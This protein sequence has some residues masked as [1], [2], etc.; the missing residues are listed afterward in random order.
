MPHILR[1]SFLLSLSCLEKSSE[2][3]N[4]EDTE[5]TEDTEEALTPEGEQLGDC[6]DGEDNDNDGAIDC[7]DSGCINATECQES[8]TGAPD[9][10]DVPDDTDD[11]TD[12]EP[13][14]SGDDSD[15]DTEAPQEFSGS[16]VVEVDYINPT[17][18]SIGYEDCTTA[19]VY[20]EIT[21][22][23][24]VAGCP[25]CTHQWKVDID[26]STDCANENPP[27]NLIGDYAID[28]N[29]NIFY[30]YSYTYGWFIPYD[31]TFCNG[32]L[33]A[34]STNNSFSLVCE[35]QSGTDFSR[36][37]TINFSF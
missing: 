7:E 31:T 14:D 23:V 19:Y 18:E 35:H 21:D 32:G 29:Q 13:D 34:S 17:Y 28:T 15:T 3:E 6:S 5:D 12:S 22:A 37:T 20:T 9:D 11:T 26:F 30:S 16:L 33:Q 25:N 2:T 4:T 8:D 1:L 10:T 24:M 27:E 36:T